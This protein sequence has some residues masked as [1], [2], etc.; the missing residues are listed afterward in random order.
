MKEMTRVYQAWIHEHYP[1][2]DSARSQCAVATSAM[3]VAFPE[4]IRVRG[5]YSGIEHWWCKTDSGEIIDPTAHQ[6]PDMGLSVYAEFREGVDPEPI[7]KC[8]NCGE[9]CWE[10]SPSHCTCST[11]CERSFMASLG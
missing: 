3:V 4:L 6:F 11:E 1:T 2:S 9:Y 5:W 8:L 7:G 10:W